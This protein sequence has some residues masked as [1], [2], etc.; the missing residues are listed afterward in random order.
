MVVWGVAKKRASRRCTRQGELGVLV[1]SRKVWR[2]EKVQM[3]ERVRTAGE[4]SLGHFFLCNK[5]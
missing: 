1:K 3:L 2:E 4:V 5:R